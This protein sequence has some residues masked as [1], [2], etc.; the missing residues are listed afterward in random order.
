MLK[1]IAERE[2]KHMEKY[3]IVAARQRD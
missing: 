3:D 1:I 2:K